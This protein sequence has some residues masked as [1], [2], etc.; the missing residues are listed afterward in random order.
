MAS[1]IRRLFGGGGSSTPAPVAAK[2]A[3]PK[4]GAADP[5]TQAQG[6]TQSGSTKTKRKGK[7]V[8]TNQLGL[9]PEQRSG[10]NLKSLTGQ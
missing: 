7:T 10:I 5:S 8:Y 6:T 4:T 2:P 1:F 3:A 9:T